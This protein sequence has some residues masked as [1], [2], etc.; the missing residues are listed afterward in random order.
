MRRP[1]NIMAAMASRVSS[2][3]FVGRR[4][5]LD[6]VTAWLRL[7]GRGQSA[8]FLVSGEAGVGKTRFVDEII[9]VARA[10]EFRVLTGGCLELAEGA[11]PFGPIV[12]AL[13]GLG[14]E[15][16]PPTLEALMGAGRA[17]LG[18]LLPSLEGT[19]PYSQAHGDVARG[20]L[21]ELLLGFLTRL[22]AQRPI[23]LVVEDLHWAD[24]STLDLLTFLIRSLR[25]CAIG[26]LA[27]YRSDELH[28][29]HPLLPVLAE[30][31]R[32]GRAQRLNLAR[33]DRAEL[34]AQLTGIRGSAPEPDL[35][36]SILRRSQGN[37]F[38]AEELLASGPF[39]AAIPDTLRDVLF[40]RIS[41]LSAPTQELLQ[42]AAAGGM[43]IS[44]S[45]LVTVSGIDE[46]HLVAALREAVDRQILVPHEGHGTG[47]Y[48]FR[49]ALVQEAAY[50]GLLPG[51][52][53]ALHAAFARTLAETSDQADAALAAEIAYHWSAAHDLPRALDASVAAGVAAES[54][55]A[56]PEAETQYERA[57]ELWDRVPD[58][59]RRA[60]LG[61]VEVLERAAHT[62]AAAG[63]PARSAAHI[64]TALSLVD[65][66][67]DPLR[68]GLLYERLG[69]YC[70]DAADGD[71]AIA[72][73]RQAV[74]L[75]PAE[76]PSSAR[77]QVLAEL[78]RCLMENDHHGEAAPLCDEAIAVAQQV[79]VR[80]IE[81]Q[82]LLS[83]ASCIGYFGNA[84][85]AIADCRRAREIAVEIRA[86]EAVAEA[87]ASLAFAL[88]MFADR[89]EDAA[90]VSLE[91][92]EYTVRN[93]LVRAA[94]RA[95]GIALIAGAAFTLA[96]TGRWDEADQALER[97]RLAGAEAESRPFNYHLF[98]ADLDIR[99][100]HLV[101]AGRRLE[102]LDRFTARDTAPWMVLLLS[103]LRAALA[104]SRA[105]P[106][107][108][109]AAVADGLQKAALLSENR[110]PVFA[111]AVYVL[112][113][114][115]EAD[116]AALARAHRSV[117]RL[118]EAR[119][120]AL[121]YL[122]RMRELSTETDRE[123]PAIAFRTAAQLALCEA[124]I[125]RLEGRSSPPAWSSAAAAFAALR[126]PHQ[127]AYALYREGEA[128]LA[129]TRSRVRAGPSLRDAHAIAVALGASPL[130]HEIEALAARG[131][132]ELGQPGRRDQAQTAAT[133]TYGLTPREIE[134]LAL[135]AA[136]WTNRRI[137][138][139]LFI[140][141]KTASVHV[142]NILGKL[143][144][145]G[146]FEA[147]AAAQR[148]GLVDTTPPSWSAIGGVEL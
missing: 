42:I 122:A 100:G 9:A 45:V 60:P 97:A 127:R 49:H 147:A 38:Y 31:E 118:V 32:S 116:L 1:G 71:A 21:F 14:T 105:D 63:D 95:S 26:L 56:F 128:L 87:Y 111:S 51:E 142:S 144:V 15:L 79:G 65:P 82:A 119:A 48:T 121:D 4:A 69:H 92:F 36:D 62:S 35:L 75:L 68:A 3:I 40:A 129:A 133:E 43:R 113:I 112:G 85:G 107:T 143:R 13:R 84:D 53:T 34:A 12:E 19:A 131:R 7:G 125:T 66:V 81:A 11:L 145:A 104:L 29:R 24:R 102:E 80:E 130:T 37:P 123:R 83:R 124:E 10:S 46:R 115:A 61:R 54:S 148:L 5:D 98:R 90:A 137:G 28:R 78:G 64:R 126:R 77:A 58:A 52:R 135:V 6:R 138:A 25:D 93:G 110:D 117:G 74:R 114:R 139:A 103:Q 27:T 76:P 96:E 30:L 44:E 140:T 59:V 2:P 39:D 55:F 67:A 91:G 132:V 57:L 99:R 136:G 88:G 18:L 16:S 47:S 70:L 101:E 94:G 41:T 141:E 72:A 86:V 23:L 134:V 73:C 120:I 89:Q 146:R 20:R 17:E 8:A 22:A 33:F 109:R 50:S 108:A 106:G